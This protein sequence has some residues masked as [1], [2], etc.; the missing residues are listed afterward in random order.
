[1]GRFL[2]LRT[3]SL[4]RIPHEQRRP[5]DHHQ[6]DD[7]K[8]GERP[9]RSDRGDEA[10]G[11]KRCHE[12]PAEAG[13][14]DARYGATLVGA[15]L[16]ERSNGHDVVEAYA[17]DDK[18]VGQVEEHEAVRGET[19]QEDP[20]S[21]MDAGCQGHYAWSQVTH[22]VPVHEGGETEDEEGDAECRVHRGSR[23]SVVRLRQR[24]G[25]YA[26]RVDRPE[27]DLHYDAGYDHPIARLAYRTRGR[28]HRLLTRLL[29]G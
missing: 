7:A 3:P 10:L 14:G 29:G 22:P 27:R 15:P 18:A 6:V 19:S 21:V 4:G 20:D 26:L 24:I 8:N 13:H 12:Q 25:D 1:M 2:A 16:D 11:D 9:E 17:D 28:G 23:D 5:H